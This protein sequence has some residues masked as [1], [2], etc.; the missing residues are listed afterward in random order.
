MLFGPHVAFLGLDCRTERMS[1]QILRQNTWD[2]VF[3]RCKGK[4]VKGETRHLIVLLGV[5][6]KFLSSFKKTSNPLTIFQA[7]CIPTA[8][9]PRKYV[10]LKGN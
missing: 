8:K 1:N 7:N 10:D 4:I 6:R 5:V 3:K 9:L 2:L